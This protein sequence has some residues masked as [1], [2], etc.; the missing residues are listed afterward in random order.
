MAKR[1]ANGEGSVRRKKNGRWEIQ[2]MVGFKPD[3]KRNIRSFSGKTQK[4][5]KAKKDAYLRKRAE[6]I[7]LGTEIRFDEWA[8]MWFGN[9]AD[10]VK[11]TTLEGYRYTLRVLKEHFGR[12]RS[13]RWTSNSF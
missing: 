4:E 9:H 2:I 10:N 1:R 11:P 8:D 12:R 13:K 5:V 6:G 7:L 3:G